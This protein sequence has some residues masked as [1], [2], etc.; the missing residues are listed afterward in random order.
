MK[1]RGARTIDPNDFQAV[2]PDAASKTGFLI[3][4]A[5]G[6]TEHAFVD[7]P[8][9]RVKGASLEKLLGRAAAA[10]LTE[11]EAATLASR[12][13]RLELDLTP[14]ERDELDALAGQ[15]VRAVVRALVDAVDPDAQALAT[16]GADPGSTEARE[17]LAALVDEAVRPLASNPELRSRIVELRRSHDLVIDELTVDELLDAHGVVDDSRARSVVESWRAYLLEN[18]AEITAVQLLD[19]APGA[20]VDFGHVEALARRIARPPHRWTTEVLWAA[21]EAVD[22]GHV[23]RNP[24]ATLTDLV[25]LMRFTL[26]ADDE[27]VPYADKVEQRYAGWLEQQAQAGATFTDDERWWLDRMTEV[28]ASSARIT[29]EDLGSAPFTERGGIDGALR[30]LGE[31]TGPLVAELDRELAG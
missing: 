4:D 13:A 21:H 29:P 31:R 26:G 20:R 19:G 3:V 24:R 9:D 18:R 16:A 11:D 5:V 17:A 30:V 23:R 25:Q 12:L 14:A 27:L 15:P 1:G 6:V 8:L 2:T 10:T 7:P 28:I 22:A